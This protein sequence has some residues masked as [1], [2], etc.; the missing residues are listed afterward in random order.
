[1]LVALLSAF[2]GA[3]TGG[4]ILLLLTAVG[5]MA[6]R[7]RLEKIRQSEDPEATTAIGLGDV[8]LMAFGGAFLGW[9]AIIA[10]FFIGTLI[11]A[12]LG[13]IEKFSTGRWPKNGEKAADPEFFLES[14]FLAFAPLPRQWREAILYR[15]QTGTSLMPYGPALCSGLLLTLFFR[16]DIIAYLTRLLWPTPMGGSSN[17]LPPFLV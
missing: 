13:I 1:Y 12:F 6:F 2:L 9:K 16:Q 14:A 17:S 3:L 10:A 11:G 15:W 7:Q 8:K 4:G 5:T